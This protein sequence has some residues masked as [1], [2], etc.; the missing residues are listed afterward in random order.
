[1][2]SEHVQGD[3]WVVSMYRGMGGGEHV[4][5]DGWVV[6]MYRGMGG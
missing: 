6:S 5:G 2:G 1:M 3:G 4:Q